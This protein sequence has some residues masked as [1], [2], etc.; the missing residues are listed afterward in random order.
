[1]SGAGSGSSD[2]RE[3]ETLAQSFERAVNQ[4]RIDFYTVYEAVPSPGLFN[5][6]HAR[7][8]KELPALDFLENILIH[9]CAN[10]DSDCDEAVRIAFDRMSKNYLSSTT[11]ELVCTRL[12][13][14]KY[15]PSEAK[16]LNFNLEMFDNE[17]ILRYVNYIIHGIIRINYDYCK[18]VESIS[19]RLIKKFDCLSKTRVSE[20]LN[21]AWREKKFEEMRKKDLEAYIE[22]QR[23]LIST[24][25]RGAEKEEASKRAELEVLKEKERVSTLEIES[26]KERLERLVQEQAQTQAAIADK[27]AA[28]EAF[29]S[30]KVAPQRELFEKNLVILNEWAASTSCGLTIMNHDER[31]LRLP[32]T[33]DDCYILMRPKSDIDEPVLLYESNGRR[34]VLAMKPEFKEAFLGAFPGVMEATETP[35]RRRLLEEKRAAIIIANQCPAPA[36]A[37]TRVF[38]AV[39]AAATAPGAPGPGIELCDFTSKFR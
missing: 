24:D 12:D 3:S 36:A 14:F 32:A 10:N 23:Q 18:D 7:E 22:Q 17:L 11:W 33:G 29:A 19:R 35:I 39:G 28:L 25:L 20:Y 9:Y 15:M 21:P 8:W 34:E 26:L 1:M 37:P 6:R 5:R 31:Q 38:E 2:S 4:F 16:L 30:A 13:Y 27:T